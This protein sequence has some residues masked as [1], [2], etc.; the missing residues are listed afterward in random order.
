MRIVLIALGLV[1]AAVLISL[2]VLTMR[3]DMEIAPD[4]GPLITSGEQDSDQPGA[5]ED[6]G[7]S[8]DIVRIDARGSAVIAGRGQ[9]GADILLYANGRQIAATT[10]DERG[11]WVIVVDTPLDEGD[12][13]LTL[14][15]ILE[16]G[17]KLTSSQIVVVAV[18]ERPGIKPLVVLGDESGGSRVL[19]QPGDGVMVG[20]LSL[21]VVDYDNKGDV[22]LQG[23]ARPGNTVRAYVD[24]TWVGE[25]QSGE[26]GKWVLT[27]E[28][29]IEPGIY[30]LRVDQIDSD[31]RVTA[32]V[33]VPFERAAPETTHLAAGQVIV[34][35]GNS[36]WRISRRLYGRGILYTVIYNANRDQIRDPDLIYPGQI[37][38]TPVLSR[39]T[40]DRP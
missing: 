1:L 17:T 18:P 28:R 19:Q 5:A 11:E 24:N 2:V 36:L 30:T 35:P 25:A 26:D 29:G 12:Q 14:G 32:R 23:R 21:D 38:E 15:M 8:F 16:D 13:E 39:D 10:A 6:I 34:Q 40:E 9:P 27:P 7:P 20:E 3:S 4:G 22:I 33:E 37:F 31:G